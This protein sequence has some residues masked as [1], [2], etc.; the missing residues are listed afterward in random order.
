MSVASSYVPDVRRWR[1][2]WYIPWF[3]AAVALTIGIGL[4]TQAA[5]DGVFSFAA[6]QPADSS[7]TTPTTASGEQWRAAARGAAVITIEI[8]IIAGLYAVYRRLPDWLQKALQDSVVPAIALSLFILIGY[9]ARIAEAPA[10]AV[11]FGLPAAF[12]GWLFFHRVLQHYGVFWPIH[13]LATVSLAGILAAVL[14]KLGLGPALGIV[15]LLAIIDPLAVHLSGYM[16]ST[17]RWGLQHA[18]P[19]AVV[20]PGSGRVDISE[21]A[22]GDWDGGDD[23]KVLGNGD[24]MLPAG[25]AIAAN[26]S[27]TV[28]LAPGLT[29][30]GA[31]GV[32]GAIAGVALTTGIRHPDQEAYPAMPAV[33]VALVPVVAAGWLLEAALGLTG[34]VA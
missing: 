12:A 23:V 20:V 9:A 18:A 13:N 19:I 5:Y 17:A 24:L 27:G 30:L 10:N 26:A 34:V 25:V 32:I 8:G 29:L 1:Y 2:Q 33:V 6:Q 11:V 7:S 28:S 3:V 4:G 31:A 15:L 16:V 22:D 21:F 14:A